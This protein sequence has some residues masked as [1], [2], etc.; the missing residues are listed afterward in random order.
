MTM[1]NVMDMI[2]QLGPGP[3]PYQSIPSGQGINSS[4]YGSQGSRSYAALVCK[5]HPNLYV[6]LHLLFWFQ[7]AIT[8][9]TGTLTSPTALQVVRQWMT[10]CTVL[11]CLTHLTFR[12]AWWHKTN[13]CP[14]TC[15]TQWVL[16]PLFF[17]WKSWIFYFTFICMFLIKMSK[18]C[19]LSIHP[20]SLHL[21]S[22]GLRRGAGWCVLI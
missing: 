3:S 4:E 11:S 14:T 18:W 8:K 12:I 2:A 6:C 9:D 21:V 10:S 15:L 7:A 22:S 5:D 1:P 16:Q 20:F 19:V 17:Y 13:P